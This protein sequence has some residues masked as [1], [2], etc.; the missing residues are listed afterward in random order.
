MA[1][2]AINAAC[3]SSQ[4][5]VKVHI[6]SMSDQIVLTAPGGNS[7]MTDCSQQI[8]VLPSTLTPEYSSSLSSSP[9]VKPDIL[10]NSA[11]LKIMLI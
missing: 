10:C 11:V 1:C 3:A 6:L 7:G 2:T 4:S 5:E 8:P 9:P